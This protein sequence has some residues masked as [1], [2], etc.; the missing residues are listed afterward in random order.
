MNEAEREPELEPDVFPELSK[1]AK[2]T[3]EFFWL[4]LPLIF[5]LGLGSGWFLWGRQ[6]AAAAA[7]PTSQVQIPDHVK[8]YVIPVDG[9]PA[10][11]PADAPITLIEFGDY[12]CPYCI[13]WYNTVANRLLTDYAGKIRF[14]YKDLPLVAIHPNAQSAAE[15]ADCAGEQMAYWKYHDA[16]FSGKHGLGA[17]AYGEYASELGLDIPAFDTCVTSH[18][19]KDKVDA[20]ASLAQNNGFN[21]TPTFLVNGLAVV[22]AQPYE[23]FQQVIDLELAGK[24]PK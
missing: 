16:L 19:Y 18:R 10:L 3:P 23:V 21:S 20:N 14:V 12:Q 11:G 4:A 13:Q 8:R 9:D 2:P 24:I 15:A 17:Q 1:P 5:L 7:L 22:G 6:T